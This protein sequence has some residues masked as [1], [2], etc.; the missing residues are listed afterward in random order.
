MSNLGGALRSDLVDDSLDYKKAADDLKQYFEYDD[1]I[2]ENP[3]VSPK[4]FRSCQERHPG[5]CDSHEAAGYIIEMV[6]NLQK[7]FDHWK[8]EAPCLCCM[9]FRLLSESASSHCS[10]PSFFKTWYMLGSVSKRPLCHVLAALKPFGQN[11]DLAFLID[12]QT[13]CI[14]LCSS[15]SIFVAAVDIAIAHQVGL[16]QLEFRYSIHQFD[17]QPSK[18]HENL[19]VPESCIADFRI[20]TGCELPSA[21]SRGHKQKDTVELPF[22]LLPAAKS[23]PKKRL[24]S[25]RK[26]DDAMLDDDTG[27]VVKKKKVAGLSTKLTQKNDTISSLPSDNAS[28]SC[29]NSGKAVDDKSEYDNEVCLSAVQQEQLNNAMIS[30]NGVEQDDANLE[31]E[32]SEQD[33]NRGKQRSFF[34]KRTGIISLCEAKRGMVCYLCNTPISKGTLRFEFVFSKQRPQRSIHTECVGHMNPKSEEACSSIAWLE[35]TSIADCLG[36]LETQ[37]VGQTLQ[38]LRA[39]NFASA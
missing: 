27:L 39:L 37:V 3:H 11:E 13:L 29:S 32:K 20:G 25:D 1:K 35:N 38:T 21:P 36:Q 12:K 9:T 26:D 22:G 8:V 31:A 18:D 16:D 17:L 10:R 19:V 30:A 7:H 15:Y 2:L 24:V 14:E 33:K 5:L 34:H 23:K 4:L 6:E 28:S